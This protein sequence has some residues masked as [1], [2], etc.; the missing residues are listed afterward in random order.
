MAFLRLHVRSRRQHPHGTDMQVGQMLQNRG[1]LVQNVRWKEQ[2]G[3]TA[4]QS[5]GM[6]DGG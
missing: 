2:Q 4:Q 6:E 5:E 1:D 3:R